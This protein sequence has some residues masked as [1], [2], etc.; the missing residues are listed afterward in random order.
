M[1]K[2][3]KLV[4][5]PR[6]TSVTRLMCWAHTSRAVDRSSYLAK[7]RTLNKEK[8][9][10]LVQDLNF[11]QWSVLNEE[12]FLAVFKLYEA[13]HQCPDLPELH[14]AVKDFLLYLREVWVESEESRYIFSL[15]LCL[16]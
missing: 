12:S 9:L 4:W 11:L 1:T 8:A 5:D 2:A 14:V 13:K 16:F 10:Q 6:E 15:K 3:L 7:V